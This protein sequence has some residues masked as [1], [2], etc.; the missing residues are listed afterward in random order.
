MDDHAFDRLTRSLTSRRGVVATLAATFGQFGLGES[1]TAATCKPLGRLCRRSADC[2]S[3][4]CLQAEGPDGRLRGR[5]RCL[6]RLSLTLPCGGRCCTRQQTCKRG[7]C[8]HHC[9]DGRIS[10]NESDKDCGGGDCPKCGLHRL[11][12]QSSDCASGLCLVQP[13][14][15][16]EPRCAECVEDGDCRNA[17]KPVCQADI[18]LCVQCVTHDH[19]PGTAPI[20]HDRTGRCVE[21]RDE[22]DCPRDMLCEGGRCEPV[23]PCS[24]PCNAENCEACRTVNGTP[25][26]VPLCNESASLCIISGGAAVGCCVPSEETGCSL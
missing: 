7:R 1:T 20:C 25:V 15:G 9:K 16:P 18:N 8:V 12:N 14:F 13:G 19:C 2:C 26:C 23:E 5:D 22:V 11:C 3:R 17:A 24:L 6:C 21:C 4:R 10:G